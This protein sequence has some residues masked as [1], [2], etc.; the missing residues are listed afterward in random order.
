[1][2]VPSL[3]DVVVTVTYDAADG[4]FYYGGD[5]KA[6]GT[7]VV[8]AL[9]AW[10]SFELYTKN[11]GSGQQPARFVDELPVEFPSGQMPAGMNTWVSNTSTTTALIE[12][13]NE[14]TSGD[15]SFPFAINIIFAGETITSPDPTILNKDIGG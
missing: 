10:I 3:I 14:A 13:L 8:N 5:A 4:K 2:A 7:I 9:K 11:E 12:D 1:M 15:E 6:D